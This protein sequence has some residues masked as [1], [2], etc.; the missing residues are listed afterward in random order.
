MTNRNRRCLGQV[1]KKTINYRVFFFKIKKSLFSFDQ[2]FIYLFLHSVH[3]IFFSGKIHIYNTF[4]GKINIFN[5]SINLYRK[6]YT[7]ITN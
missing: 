4:F 2:G 7:L 3:A 5:N 6:Y 1:F